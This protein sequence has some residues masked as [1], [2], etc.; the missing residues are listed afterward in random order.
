MQKLTT[1]QKQEMSGG[2]AIGV[3]WVAMCGV[4][5]LV[6]TIGNLINQGIQNEQ[7]RQYAQMQ[8]ELASQAATPAEVAQIMNTNASYYSKMQYTN[9]D[10]PMLKLSPIATRSTL[11]FGL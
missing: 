10:A 11:M 2:I 8:Y 9:Y 1:E 6:S 3:L 4:T 7:N 5:M